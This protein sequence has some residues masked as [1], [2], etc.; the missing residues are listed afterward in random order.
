MFPPYVKGAVGSA[1]KTLFDPDSGVTS[2]VS[3]GSGARAVSWSMR[4][5]GTSSQGQGASSSSSS[6]SA[7]ILQSIAL[8]PGSGKVTQITFHRKGDY[9]SSLCEL[10]ARYLFPRLPR[11]GLD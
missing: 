9:L 4:R 6:S 2:G 1:T 5:G 3:D 7:D 10:P 8:P 11:L